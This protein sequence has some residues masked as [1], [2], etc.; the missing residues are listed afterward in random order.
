MQSKWTYLI[1]ALLIL[2]VL[3]GCETQCPPIELECP[4][5]TCPSNEEGLD[6]VHVYFINVGQGDAQLI[7]YGTTEMLIDCGKNSMGPLVVDFLK[8]HNVN[9]LEYL[10]ITHPDSDH[11][12]GCDDVLISIP[13]QTVITSGESTDTASY[14]EVMDE[15][16]TE[17][18]LEAKVDDMWNIGPSTIKVLQTNN[19]F[20]DTNENSIV[21]KLAYNNVSVLFTGDCDNKCEDFL[22]EKDIRAGILK[23][24]HHGSKY[25]TDI[26]FLEKVN[27]SAAVISV[28]DNLYGHP[29]EETLDR[30]SQEG[31]QVYRTDLNG[32]IEIEINEIGYEVK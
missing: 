3:S 8:A 1:F 27:P 30:L 4:E 28:G 23:V 22:L 9:R 17:Q 2:L 16:D 10:M 31:V 12:G 11:L 13:T 25:A 6:N 26:D 24:A 15:I 21:A 7:K 5:C 32:N 14:K 19:H 18:L 29:T 20:N